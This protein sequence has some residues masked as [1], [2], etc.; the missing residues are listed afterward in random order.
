MY[1]DPSAPIDNEAQRF[2]IACAINAADGRPYPIVIDPTTGQLVVGE[3][4]GG[5]A[6]IRVDYEKSVVTNFDEPDDLERLFDSDIPVG[7]ARA[8][9]GEDSD[10]EVFLIVP[11]LLNSIVLSSD[12]NSDGYS[13]M[14]ISLIDLEENEVVVYDNSADNTQKFGDTIEFDPRFVRG[15]KIE[16]IQN[17]TGNA[18]EV[19]E[20]TVLGTSFVALTSPLKG[21][22]EDPDAYKFIQ[23]AR[24]GYYY[25][26]DASFVVGDSPV[27]LDVN[28]DLGRNA[29]DGYIINDGAGNIE[30]EISHDGATWG[31]KFVWKLTD[32]K[33]DL[34]GID[35]DSIRIT[36]VADSS[37][38]VIV[39]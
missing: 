6:G 15:F 39:R 24:E 4:G 29:S 25:Y 9:A 10:I 20:L 13:N 3:G 32:G 27:I 23:G 38:R 28:N 31:Q 35:A 1:V 18:L 36:W 11:A 33:F 5:G 34:K 16:W 2:V 19:G 30:I 22:E 8:A 26:V 12:V 14:K 17:G 21:Y 7:L 37:Y